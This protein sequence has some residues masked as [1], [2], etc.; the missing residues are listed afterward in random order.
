MAKKLPNIFI[1]YRRDD[2][3]YQAQILHHALNEQGNVFM[4]VDSILPGDDLNT[5]IYES[6]SRADVILI[7]I[8]P[9]WLSANLNGQ[10]RIDDP[11]DF[12]RLEL[13]AALA[14]DKIL[15]PVLFDTSMPSAEEVPQSLQRLVLH[16]A[17]VLRMGADFSR[18]VDRL[19]D[20]MRLLV[21]R[22]KNRQQ[23]PRPVE[24]EKYYSCF[25]SYAHVDEEFCRLLTRDLR[26]IG[27]KVWFA[28]EDIKGGQK[29][30]KQIYNAIQRYDRL[31]LV[32]SEASINSDWVAKEIKRA[33]KREQK[34]GK[35]VLFPIRLSSMDIIDNWELMDGSDD[36]A[37]EVRDYYIMDF[38]DW[39]NDEVYKLS[40]SKLQDS[41]RMAAGKEFAEL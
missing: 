29:I 14:Q 6:I 25:I 10:R 20:A 33:R 4:D 19:K 21:S 26:D 9:N 7:L 36:L 2:T 34:E 37:R 24:T 18:D 30:L 12:I 13:E 3:A 15:V 23:I 27:I 39:R 5:A 41:L 1:S 40:F 28:D 11:H 38:S 8:G 35:E 32:L 16:N 22:E 31:L 17:L